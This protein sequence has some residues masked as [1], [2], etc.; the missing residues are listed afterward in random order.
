MR[1]WP[2]AAALL[3]GACG[4]VAFTIL[5]SV[6]KS[7]FGARSSVQP[8]ELLTSRP[9]AIPAPRERGGANA[10]LHWGFG[11]S[12]G[13]S[14][15]ALKDLLG[16]RDPALLLAHFCVVWIPWRLLSAT[17]SAPARPSVVLDMANHLLF[18][19]V[20]AGADRLLTTRRFTEGINLPGLSD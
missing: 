13:L 15:L 14:R 18:V 17:R 7:R 3:S 11:L 19:G 9:P 16:W 4:T 8:I 6:E 1:R 20:I 10:V 12:A 2:M 5:R